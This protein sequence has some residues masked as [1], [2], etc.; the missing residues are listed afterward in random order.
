MVNPLI[1]SRQL[2]FGGF[3]FQSGKNSKQGLFKFRITKYSLCPRAFCVFIPQPEFEAHDQ[4]PQDIPRPSLC[5]IKHLRM[6][7]NKTCK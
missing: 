4:V 6:F 3:Q 1:N 5:L 2:Y 7:R